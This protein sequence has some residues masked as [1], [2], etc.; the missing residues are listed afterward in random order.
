[1][2]WVCSTKELNGL[3]AV[4]VGSD[5]RTVEYSY[6]MFLKLRRAFFKIR[7]IITKRTLVKTSQG[8][9]NFVN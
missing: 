8:A 2:C 3:V 1:M 7:G 6:Q 4:S 9:Y 5:V